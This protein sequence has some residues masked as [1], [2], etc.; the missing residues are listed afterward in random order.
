MRI[1]FSGEPGSGRT[2]AAEYLAEMYGFGLLSLEDKLKFNLI[3]IGLDVGRMFE[4]KDDTSIALMELYGEAM[5]E[6]DPLHWLDTVLE[7]VEFGESLGTD[8]HVIDDLCH[9]IEG[10][11]LRN[12]GFWLVR[13]NKSTGSP[14]CPPMSYRKYNAGDW[15]DLE[16][17]RTINVEEGD[18]VDLYGKLDKMVSEFERLE[19]KED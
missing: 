11:I 4:N 7:G 9:R 13:I 8:G 12:N 10:D 18:L 2:T 3:D 14:M 15:K 19:A 16:F 6:Q 1:A 5:R 17:N